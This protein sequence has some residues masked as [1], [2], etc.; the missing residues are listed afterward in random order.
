MNWWRITSITTET[1]GEIDVSYYAAGLRRRLHMPATPDSNTHALLPGRTGRSPATT[2]ADHRLVP[3]VRRRRG[4]RGRPTGGAPRVIT[5][6]DVPGRAGLAL[7]RR[8]RARPGDAARP[9]A[10]GA[11][12][13]TVTTTVGEPP[14]PQTQTDSPLLPGHERRQDCR[15]A[16][17]RR[18][19]PTRPA[20]ATDD[21]AYAGMTRETI[22]YN[23]VGGAEVVRRR[24][25]TPWK[26][27]ATATRTIG[28][29]HHVA[30][31][32]RHRRDHARTALDGGR[33]YR[34]PRPT[35]PS[36]PYGLPTQVRTTRATP[37]RRPTTPA[38]SH[39]R[40][41]TPRLNILGTIGRVQ[42][43]ARPCGH[44][45]RRARR[46]D[47]RRPRTALRRRSAYGAAPT[48]GD[49]THRADGQD[50]D[51][52]GDHRR[53][54]PTATD[55]VRRATAGPPTSPT[56]RG[57]THDHRLH[58][59]D[60]R[61]GHLGQTMTR[62]R[63]AGSPPPRSTRP[64]AWPPGKVDPTA[65]GPTP[66]TTGS[67]GRPRSGSPTAAKSG[68]QTRQRHLRL[69]DQ[70]ANGVPSVVTTSILNAAGNY[71][72]SYAFYDGLLRAAAADPGVAVRTPAAARS[73]PTRST[74]RVGE[75]RP[76]TDGPYFN[77][78]GAG[79]DA[80]RRRRST[81]VPAQTVD[82]LRRRRPG[83]RSRR[84]AS[85]TSTQWHT[86]TAYGG[87]HTDVT[88]PRRRHPTSTLH[89]RARPHRPRCAQYPGTD[90]DRP[91]YN[92]THYTYDVKGQR[93]QRHR[94]RPA[95]S[96]RYTYDLLGRETT[97]H[98]PGHRHH[99]VA[100]STTPAT[101]SP[102]PTPTAPPTRRHT[103]PRYDYDRPAPAA[104]SASGTARQH[105][106][107][108]RHLDLRHPRQRAS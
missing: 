103:R 79:D 72:T 16:P 85:T 84:P 53:S 45:V 10:S 13:D 60:G 94:R 1:G 19:S 29:V 99:H 20:P 18:R 30:R 4:H 89:R 27:A 61:P 63:S 65:S 107:Q 22:T 70:P 90:A 75:T 41:A 35:P 76:T 36:T 21:D 56:S 69:H 86:T 46:R 77:A 88:P 92:S 38:R 105:R 52:P 55:R 98:R 80:V 40:P 5:H 95:T 32:H 50:L 66:P 64:A 93:T 9:G 12:T 81:D 31:P 34:G 82:H 73:S 7:R 6:Y 33:G 11:A 49:V 74:T 37:P 104:R 62:T 67:A 101:C 3:Q 59:G 28:G 44:A 23:G 83:H 108:A 97:A 15:P 102:S 57:N 42:T 91:A 51:Q 14:D 68:S 87:D 24:S 100:R 78:A 25:T 54:R 106:H 17:G 48:K 96:G 8:R 47:L 43:F 58:A 71:G 39:L 2:D 26:S